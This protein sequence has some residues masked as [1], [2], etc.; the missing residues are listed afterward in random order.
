MNGLWL[1]IYWECHHPNW[2]I[3]FRGVETTN[4]T[5]FSVPKQVGRNP[6]FCFS[7]S[8]PRVFTSFSR[9]ASLRPGESRLKTKEQAPGMFYG[10]SSGFMVIWWWFTGIWIGFA[11]DL[12][13]ILLDFMVIWGRNHSILRVERGYTWKEL[14]IAVDARRPLK[15]WRLQFPDLGQGI[16]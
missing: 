5:G 10:I 4:Q 8:N 11:W 16:L 1:P 6:V 9:N 12:N 15:I 3:F 13:G 14:K 2:I 7:G